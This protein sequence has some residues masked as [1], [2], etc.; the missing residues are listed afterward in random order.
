MAE[1]T[2]VSDFTHY[3]RFRGFSD[4]TIE[5]RGST[6]TRFEAS[7][8]PRTIE[9][10][11][12][13]DVTAF[14][15]RYKAPRTRH[16][17]LS[18]VRAFYKWACKRGYCESDPTTMIDSVRVPK[19]LPRPINTPNLA[20]IVNRCPD[21]DTRLMLALGLY[22]GLRRSEIAYLSA[23]DIAG[24]HLVVRAGKGNKDRMVSLHPELERMLA[25]MTGRLFPCA[26]HTVGRRVKDELARQGIKA[27][28]HQLRH[29]FGTELARVTGGDLL[30]IGQLMGHA[31]TNT[32][33]GYTQLGSGRAAPMVAAMYADAS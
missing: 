21:P 29:T 10:A 27:T 13:A 23:D 12:E 15:A 6:L 26:P 32:T 14:L 24:G 31:S 20:E 28:T 25:G 30:L 3:Q 17:Y 5:R 1:Q 7:I 33:L 4:A 8:H 18:D 11:T 9:Q 19:S 2:R 16:A 22:A